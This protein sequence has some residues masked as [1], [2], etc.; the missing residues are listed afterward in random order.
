MNEVI[1]IWLNGSKNYLAGV[2]LYDRY[3]GSDDLK[4]FFA[5][6]CTPY[7]ESRLLK[8]L[9]D[10][11]TPTVKD[12]PVDTEMTTI[13]APA[14][15]EITDTTLLKLH[16]EK[17]LLHKQ[18]DALRYNLSRYTSDR[19]RGII[20]HRILQYRREISAVW[21]R[22]QYYKQYG[23]L[24]DD[25][26]K[27]INSEHDL[28]YHRSRTNGNARRYRS[29]LNKDPNNIKYQ[30]LLAKWEGEW[31]QTKQSIKEQKKT[32]NE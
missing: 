4:S 17:V 32:K 29:L 24:P 28:K 5:S 9:T 25:G 19:E 2:A 8:E 27:Q 31:T 26:S 30:Q 10:L 18:K 14:A 23:H 12:D 1:R 20:A 15:V 22:E 13:E 7:R 11:V 16:E 6:G 3:G 21:E